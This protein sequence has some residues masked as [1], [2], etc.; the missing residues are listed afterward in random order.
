MALH[1]AHIHLDFMSNAREVAL[2]ARNREVQ[3]FANSVTPTGFMRTM[4]L[5]DRLDSVRI[6]LGQHPWWVAEANLS[7]F[8]ELLPTT[9]WV[10]EVGL[11]LSPRRSH[12]KRQREVFFHIAKR[13]ASAG[14]KVLSIHSV[15]AANEV[16][17]IL[18]DTGCTRSCKCVFHWFSGST[19]D[20]WRAIRAGCWFSVNQMQAG[21]RRAKEQLKLIPANRLLL[22]TDLPP[23]EGKPF[24][25]CE[26]ERSL[27]HA[28]TLLE[29]IR[30]ET[31][32]TQ[33][34]KNWTELAS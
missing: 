5:A 6:G 14:N 28:Q 32:T 13:C 30:S 9:R 24:D 20:L 18:E 1:D 31:L 12:H 7:L 33:L 15:R 34:E 11:D 21:T 25:F 8:D 27:M 16:L 22:E 19:E 10:G 2:E 3:L 23:G 4:E 17:T 29:H 26:I